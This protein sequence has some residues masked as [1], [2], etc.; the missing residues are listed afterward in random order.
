MPS[1]A[2]KKNSKQ[3]R[4]ISIL[5]LKD[6][7]L[8][9]VHMQWLIAKLESS[10]GRLVDSDVG[11]NQ[12]GWRAGWVSAYGLLSNYEMADMQSSGQKHE[13]L[14]EE[15]EEDEWS[16]FE[17]CYEWYHS[18]DM[19]TLVR[20]WPHQERYNR[21][22][23]EVNQ[24]WGWGRV[25]GGAKWRD[26]MEQ[27]WIPSTLPDMTDMLY[28]KKKSPCWATNAKAHQDRKKESSSWACQML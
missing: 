22:S 6:G 5:K 4:K 23:V 12:L 17:W 20:T 7:R 27:M 26:C 18:S 28:R 25:V 19:R 10:S 24:G 14:R 8:S 1:N 21:G 11:M 3:A 13:D 2:V 9:M 16:K 15:K